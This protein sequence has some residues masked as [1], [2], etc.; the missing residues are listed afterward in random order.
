[1]AYSDS[2]EEVVEKNVDLIDHVIKHN[3]LYGHMLKAALILITDAY[4]KLSV[5]KDV[6]EF[7]KKGLDADPSM[8]LS[9]KGA[10]HVIT[11][12]SF[13]LSITHNA[14]FLLF[15]DIPSKLESVL[16]FRTE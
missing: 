8:N 9:S 10:W 11:G 15:L 5:N 3:D 7:I 13:G 1:M 16:L 6:S 14:K 2:E 4:K 12:K